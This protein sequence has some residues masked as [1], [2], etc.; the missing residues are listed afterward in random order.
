MKE[1]SQAMTLE[2]GA[3]VLSQWA[4]PHADVAGMRATLQQLAAR[5]T[6]LGAVRQSSRQEKPHREEVEEIAAAL[7]KVLYDEF[8][9]HGNVQDYYNPENSLL[10]RVLDRRRGIP[11]SLCIVWSAVARR[12]GLE[13]HPLAF[14]PQHVLIRVPVR[15][16]EMTDGLG[17]ETTDLY[18]DAFD[19]GKIMDWESVLTFLSQTLNV[20]PV[21]LPASVIEASGFY[22]R[23]VE[24]QPPV[25]LYMRLLS[26]LMHIFRSNSDARLNGVLR[27]MQ[28]LEEAHAEQ[29]EQ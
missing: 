15:R 12:V 19:G 24:V 23:F 27:Q 16:Q 17:L 10:H 29:Q 6:A 7:N 13:S 3:L 2:E 20:R 8:G 14:M 4:Y 11:I 18:I 28:A 21:D 1:P 9:L 26:N 5:A 22:Q 25:R